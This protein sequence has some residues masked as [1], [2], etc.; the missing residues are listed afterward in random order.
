MSSAEKTPVDLHCLVFLSKFV[1]MLPKESEDLSNEP[2]V[3]PETS[4]Y[5]IREIVDLR[6]ANPCK[7]RNALARRCKSEG[8]NIGI[9][10][11]VKS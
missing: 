9:F 3:T 2:S 8:S 1:A 10:F 7:A 6:N 4:G 5:Q 11:L